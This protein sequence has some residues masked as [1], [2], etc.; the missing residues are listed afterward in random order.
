MCR[1]RGFNREVANLFSDFLETILRSNWVDASGIFNI[2]ELEFST[3]E[4][5]LAKII[6]GKEKNELLGWLAD[7]KGPTLELCVVRI[8]Q[9]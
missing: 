2:D 7:K 3:V 6:A 8:R 1:A 4:K 5:N 9:A